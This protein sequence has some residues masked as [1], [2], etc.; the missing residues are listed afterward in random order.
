MWA[1]RLSIVDWVYS[2]T[3]ILRA[4]LRTQNR[5]RVDYYVFF[6]E[7]NIRSHQLDAQETNVSISQFY[8]IR[9]YFV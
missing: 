8:R 1:T 3:E 2:K 4:T 5:S 9:N 6:W 7:S